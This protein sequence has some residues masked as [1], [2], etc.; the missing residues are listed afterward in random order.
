MCQSVSV[1]KLESRP[2]YLGE[3]L[4]ALCS[5]DDED[6]PDGPATGPNQNVLGCHR[7]I[8]L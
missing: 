8:R 1:S 2:G 7:A 5:V 3:G 4:E 6:A